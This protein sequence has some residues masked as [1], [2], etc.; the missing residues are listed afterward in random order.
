MLETVIGRIRFASS[1]LFGFGSL[2]GH[3]AYDEEQY[4]CWLHL[5][6]SPFRSVRLL[7]VFWHR[8]DFKAVSAYHPCADDTFM[9]PLF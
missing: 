4:Y 2:R 3:R 5:R 1:L 6:N 7:V 8:H 9:L